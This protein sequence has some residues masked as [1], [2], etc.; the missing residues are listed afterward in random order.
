MLILLEY[1]I[2]IVH[3]LVRMKRA[4]ETCDDMQHASVAK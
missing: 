4:Q 1:K 2:S 3:R